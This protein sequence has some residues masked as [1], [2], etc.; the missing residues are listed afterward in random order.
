MT[1]AGGA[2][3][4]V[5]R[6]FGR[7]AFWLAWVLDGATWGVVSLRLANRRQT[8][9]SPPRECRAGQEG[10]DGLDATD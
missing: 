10:R 8:Q 3:G 6:R 2:W 7:V 1:G 5:A 4:A 9:K